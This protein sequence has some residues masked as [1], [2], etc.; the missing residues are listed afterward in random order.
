MPG[1]LFVDDAVLLLVWN[2]VRVL[3]CWL[4]LRVLGWVLSGFWLVGLL[5]SG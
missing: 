4:V 2:D 1:F 3:R 5:R